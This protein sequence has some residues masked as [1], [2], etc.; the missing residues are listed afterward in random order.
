MLRNYD[1]FCC[2]GVL[3]YFIFFK[4]AVH[5]DIMTYILLRTVP[6]QFQ[7][8]KNYS[9]LTSSAGRWKKRGG[10]VTRGDLWRQTNRSSRCPGEEMHVHVRRWHL[11]LGPHLHILAMS[12]LPQ[13]E[14]W[15]LQAASSTCVLWD[16]G[17]GV[18]VGGLGM[19]TH[20]FS[21]FFFCQ[22]GQE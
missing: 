21:H 2:L 10:G 4:P 19:L 16:L 7:S 12:L 5:F 13:R 6:R 8:Y 9:Q 15:L 1:Y 20:I 17:W 18:H 22:L 11:L 14:V 3:L